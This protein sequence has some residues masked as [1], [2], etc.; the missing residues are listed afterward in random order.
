MSR[1]LSGDTI[2]GALIFNN[3]ERQQILQPLSDIRLNL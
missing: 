3:T 2:S 1:A